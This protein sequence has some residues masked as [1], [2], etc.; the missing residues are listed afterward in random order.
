MKAVSREVGRMS[1]ALSFLTVTP[2]PG[3][4]VLEGSSAYFPL[5]GWL[6]GGLLFLV[7]T[8]AGSLPPLVR[9]FLTVAV[10][11]LASRGLHLDA[12]ADTADGLV[13]GGSRERVL[14][15]MSDSSTGA[16]GVAAI[17]LALLGKFALLASLGFQD[18]RGA[19][20]C[21]AVM[22]R[23][24]LSLLCCLFRPA[25][26]GGLG[27]VIISSSGARELVIAT[28]IGVAPLAVLFRWHAL[29]AASGLAV[30]LLLALYARLKLGGLTGDVVG[31]GLELSEL[32]ALFSFL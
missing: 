21:A 14:G 13:A 19:L 28:V 27:N 31:A 18:G 16:F 26:E 1:A 9:A 20:V 25:K 32:S 12:L 8:A 11:E 23:Y 4:K 22:G 2:V 17:A 6:L 29:Y 30:P 24:S 3:R 5:A 15:I 7:W 10:W